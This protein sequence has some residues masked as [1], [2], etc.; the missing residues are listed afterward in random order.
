MRVNAAPRWHCPTIARLRPARYP[1]PH[2]RQSG[3]QV[4]PAQTRRQGSL[5]HDL[6]LAWLVVAAAMATPAIIAVAGGETLLPWLAE[7]LSVPHPPC[8]LCGMT[9]AFVALGQG[10]WRQALAHHPASV[11]LFAALLGQVALASG[12]LAWRRRFVARG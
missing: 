6:P 7:R 2:R 11:Y 10:Q 3:A 8:V 9:S 1:L 5:A 12:W 4:D